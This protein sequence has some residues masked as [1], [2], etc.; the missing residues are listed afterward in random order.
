MKPF[1]I[2]VILSFTTVLLY[3]S[4]NNRTKDENQ[5]KEAINKAMEKEK[6]Y[7]REQR[8]YNADEY[9]FKGAQ[10]DPKTL[11]KIPVLEPDY[12]FDMSTGV[13]D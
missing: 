5:T 13:Y 12:D 2:F 3:S 9:D 10:V 7:A 6:E 1:I 4:E 11:E 8:F